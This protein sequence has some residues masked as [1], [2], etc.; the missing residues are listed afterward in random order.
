MI[1]PVAVASDWLQQEDEAKQEIPRTAMRC[2]PRSRARQSRLSH[3]SYAAKRAISF[4]TD[5]EV[6]LKPCT[7]TQIHCFQH[8][9]TKN[10]NNN[11]GDNIVAYPRTFFEFPSVCLNNNWQYCCCVCKEGGRSQKSAVFAIYFGLFLSFS[12]TSHF[13]PSLPV[14]DPAASLGGNKLRSRRRLHWCPAETDNE[15]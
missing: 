2:R 14:A 10:G 5:E 9:N 12:L 13:P 15:T 1:V 6:S 3:L 11:I 8:G 4:I 7:M